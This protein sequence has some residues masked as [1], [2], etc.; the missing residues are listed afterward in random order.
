MDYPRRRAQAYVI[1]KLEETLSYLKEIKKKNLSAVLFSFLIWFSNYTAVYVIVNYMGINL[2][3]YKMIAAFAFISIISGLPINGILGFGTL[4]ATWTV[5]FL[6]FG[7]SKEV[8]ISSAFSFHL[9]NILFFLVWGILG[10]MNHN[11]KE[12][13]FFSKIIKDSS[14][15]R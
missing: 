2:E 14:E 6:F 3:F 12:I 8:A 9:I 5:A 11:F 15:S 4:E 13:K 10:L 7:I 1:S